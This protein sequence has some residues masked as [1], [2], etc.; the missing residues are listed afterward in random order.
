MKEVSPSY[1]AGWIYK[2]CVL[3]W[4][5]LYFI[6]DAKWGYS[7]DSG[8]RRWHKA[9]PHEEC[10]L[11]RQS[12]I[13]IS[14]QHTQHVNYFDHLHLHH[15]ST[16]PTKIILKNNGKGIELRIHGRHPTITGGGLEDKYRF[17]NI[18]FH[19][20]STSGSGSEHTVDG[21]SYPLE[22]HLVHYNSRYMSIGEALESGTTDALAVIGVLFHISEED[23]PQFAELVASLSFVVKPH[24]KSKMS[25]VF[26]LRSL[27]PRNVQSF[28]RYSGSLTTPSCNQVVV[29]TV[30]KET[31]PISEAQMESFRSLYNGHSDPM[32]DNYRPTQPLYNR[33]VYHMEPYAYRAPT[34]SGASGNVPNYWP[35]TVAVSLNYIIQLL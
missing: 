18:H 28:Y 14:T 29:W 9:S 27:L 11:Q 23:N 25:T 22:M 31:V 12:P 33:S 21:G 30:L 34:D 26:P 13:D 3:L 35:L 24:R 15:Y 32:V 6:L 2:C 10:G 4:T 5:Y 16:N 20:G 7:G 17:Y 8:P 1:Y 19:W